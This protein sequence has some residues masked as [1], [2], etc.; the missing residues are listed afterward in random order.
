MTTPAKP[1]FDDLVLAALGAAADANGFIPITPANAVPLRG[2][3]IAA[4]LQ[5]Q[6]LSLT[7]VDAEAAFQRLLGTSALAYGVDG[8]RVLFAPRFSRG[9]RRVPRSIYGAIGQSDLWTRQPEHV[10]RVWLAALMT[11][12]SEGIVQPPDGMT[13]IEALAWHAADEGAESLDAELVRQAVD[14]LVS[15]ERF[16]HDGG[17]LR[18]RKFGG[19]Q[20]LHPRQRG[21]TEDTPDGT[22]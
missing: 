4:L 22:T 10:R 11:C 8:I 20:K 3:Q 7:D 9:P 16:T 17:R 21:T 12:D 14:R 1:T 13:T 2:R 19:Y 15:S 6:G 18:I 5:R